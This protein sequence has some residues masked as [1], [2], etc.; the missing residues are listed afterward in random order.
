MT[1]RTGWAEDD[2]RRPRVDAMSQSDRDRFEELTAWFADKGARDPGDWAL[3]EVSEDI[4]QAARFLFLRAVWQNLHDVADE[5]L[6]SARGRSLI[7]DGADPDQLRSLVRSGL[8]AL[9]S[10]LLYLV[11]E[12]EGTSWPL[13]EGGFGSFV[14]RHDARWRLTE[15]T[16]EGDQTGRDVG[17]LH[18]SILDTGPDGNEGVD[19]LQARKTLIPITPL[20]RRI[21][22][23]AAILS[24]GRRF[25]TETRKTRHVEGSESWPGPSSLVYSP[26]RS[27]AAFASR[28]FGGRF[29]GPR[30]RTPRLWSSS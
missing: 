2:G 20:G 28:P 27:V 18:E 1:D 30:A 10:R 6:N 15:T 9:A 29:A 26:P 14:D 23:Q 3:S 16:P 17:A 11:D 4:A 22:C 21:A 24:V 12:P 13:P 8:F 5:T 19:W 7:A 25:S